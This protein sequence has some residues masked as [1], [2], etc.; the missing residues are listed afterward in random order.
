MASSGPFDDIVVPTALAGASGD[1]VFDRAGVRALDRAVIDEFGVP[2][3]ALMENAASAL[4]HVAFAMMRALG[5]SSALI[6]AGPGNNGGDGCALA[7]RLAEVGARVGVVIVFDADR[8]RGDALLN[9]RVIE[10]MAVA[11][12]HAEPHAMAD[13]LFAAWGALG[14]AGLIVDAVFGTGLTSAPREPLSGAL[15]WINGA[16]ADAGDA[17]AVLAVD[18]PSGLDCDRGAPAGGASGEMVA[19]ADVTVT[20]AGWK[21]GFLDPHSARFTG[22]VLTAGIGAP[23]EAT[24]KFA[25]RI[26]G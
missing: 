11:I 8:A 5:R 23:I 2:G 1:Y 21:R 4:T 18:I 7:R 9:L 6:V 12:D 25:A 20:L 17:A 14:G 10:R 16:R 3:V 26:Q 22:R 13:S 15:G 19:R 24:R